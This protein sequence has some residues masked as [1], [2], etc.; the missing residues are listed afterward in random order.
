M[1]ERKE[2]NRRERVQ[3]FKSSRVQEISRF[4]D[5]KSSREFKSSEE[6]RKREQGEQHSAGQ[7]GDCGIIYKNLRG[8]VRSPL[9]ILSLWK[10]TIIVRSHCNIRATQRYIG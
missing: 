4:Q 5:F 7:I 3:E 9:Q 6:K 8:H 10:G 1:L 2:R